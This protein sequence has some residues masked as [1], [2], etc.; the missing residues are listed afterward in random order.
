MVAGK[1]I[2]GA[3]QNEEED[4]SPLSFL[5]SLVIYPINIDIETVMDCNIGTLYYLDLN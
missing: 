2:A 1:G 3:A 5:H 4:C